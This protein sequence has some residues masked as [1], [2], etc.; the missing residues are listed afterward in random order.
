MTRLYGD[1]TDPVLEL[2]EKN[3]KQ[4]RDALASDLKDEL[5]LH[6][7][8]SD[9]P[10]SVK[11]VAA[12]P[13]SGTGEGEAYTDGSMCALLKQVKAAK[14]HTFCINPLLHKELGTILEAFELLGF[15]ATN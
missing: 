4:L 10:P 2:C 14:N 7:D 6:S 15:E 11:W 9:T 3:L 5:A 13:L 8:L 12:S 1:L